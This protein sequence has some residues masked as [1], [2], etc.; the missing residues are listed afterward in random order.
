MIQ[1]EIDETDC[2]KLML[3]LRAKEAAFVLIFKIRV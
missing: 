3:Q 1:K 2:Y